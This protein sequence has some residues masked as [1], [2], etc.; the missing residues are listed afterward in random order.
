MSSLPRADWNALRSE[1]ANERGVYLESR[2]HIV[3]DPLLAQKV[4]CLDLSLRYLHQQ[5]EASVADTNDSL[6]VRYLGAR[7]LNSTLS[8]LSLML[9]GYYQQSIFAMRDLMEMLFLLDE[10]QSCPENIAEWAG[11]E[12]RLIAKK[13]K[14]VAVRNRLNKRDGL[15]PRHS[16]R[17]KRY[18]ICCQYGTHPTFKGF[19]IIA[20]HKAVVQ[21][22]FFDPRRLRACLEETLMLVCRLARMY[23]LCLRRVREQPEPVTQLFMQ[24][25][26]SLS[27][28]AHLP[29]EWIWYEPELEPHLSV[30]R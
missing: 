25:C 15:D 17:N 24:L 20:K 1:W 12:H 14:P 13:Y 5:D 6:T 8:A 30:Y 3:Q 7:A 9:S 21:G 4:G 11:A 28:C 18:R 26:D 22:A 23:A 19:Q 16:W 2:R 27:K 10:F 29:F